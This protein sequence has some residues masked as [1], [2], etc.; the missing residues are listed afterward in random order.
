VCLLNLAFVDVDVHCAFLFNA[1]FL[2]LPISGPSWLLDELQN[3]SA[4]PDK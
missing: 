1:A 4:L 2:W 3:S